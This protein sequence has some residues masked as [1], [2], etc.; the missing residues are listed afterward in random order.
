MKQLFKRLIIFFTGLPIL[1]AIVLFLPQFNHFAFN[2]VVITVSILGAME[3]Q[4][5]LRQKNMPISPAEAAVLGG[6]SPVAVAGAVCFN[7]GVLIVPAALILGASWLL[8]SRV[9][10]SGETLDAAVSRGAAGFSVLVYPGSFMAWIIPLSLLPGS[11]AL[12]L[13]FLLMCYLNDAAAWAAGIGL[14]KGNRGIVPA[15]PNKSVA[16]FAGGLLASV[17]IGVIAARW[18]PDVFNA[19]RMPGLLAGAVLG[20]MTGVAATLGDLG[21]SALKRSAGLKDSGVIIPGRGGILDSIDSL[22]AAAPVYYI[23]YRLLFM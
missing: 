15:S 23:L 17:A 8:V 18:V 13:V 12:I 3:F 14:G 2:C 19:P 4:N 16:G 9:F 11:K 21:E 10:S 20:L 5:F 7:F 1:I 22:A 6:I